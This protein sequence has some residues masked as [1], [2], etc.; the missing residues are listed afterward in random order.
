MKDHVEVN[1]IVVGDTIR[2]S[3]CYVDS[4]KARPSDGTVL[5][6]VKKIERRPDGTHVMWME[7]AADE[8]LSTQ[9]P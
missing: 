4:L 2:M 9:L 1:G 5:V 8:S 7:N 6:R 3:T